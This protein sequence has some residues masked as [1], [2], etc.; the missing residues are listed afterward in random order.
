MTIP[1]LLCPSE[2]SPLRDG[3]SVK[4]CYAY[5]MGNQRMD[6]NNTAWGACNQYFVNANPIPQGVLA[7]NMFGTGEAGHGNT[8]LAGQTSGVASRIG[9]AANFRDITDGTSNVI[10][11]GEVRPQCGDHM[12]NGWMH[13]NSMWVATT[14]PINYPIACVRM[15]P[16]QDGTVWNDPSPR[17]GA[18]TACNHWQ[19]WTTSQGF[20]SRH[21]GG[22]QFV[23]GDGSVHFISENIDYRSY[24]YLGDRRD[25]NAV[26]VQ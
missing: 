12:R 13:F 7:G 17:T 3:H 4:S 1:V 15:D 22:A 20:K 2:D 8:M 11:M 19:N 9:W 18:T 10:L 6:P 24:Q 26:S 25:G 5:S 14:A 16:L 21:P 23:M